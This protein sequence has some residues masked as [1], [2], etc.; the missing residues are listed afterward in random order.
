MGWSTSVPFPPSVMKL[1]LLVCLTL[2]L[3]AHATLISHDHG[4][5]A[6]RDHSQLA[7]R[8]NANKRCKPKTAVN[9]S[10]SPSSAVTMSATINNDSGPDRCGAN[11]ATSVSF[12]PVTHCL[13]LIYLYQRNLPLQV[14]P[15]VQRI[16]S[17]V[18]Y[19]IVAGT[20]RT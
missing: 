5:I 12:N 10:P 17:T 15:M 11:G 1:V 4:I 9:S 14:V 16:G 20:H 13:R 6:R 3:L 8:A 2:S 7:R 18:D 19:T